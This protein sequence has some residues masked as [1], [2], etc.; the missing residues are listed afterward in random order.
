MTDHPPIDPA[1]IRKGDHV[2]W[3]TDGDPMVRYEAIEYVALR[4]GDQAAYQ[5][6]TWTLIARAPRP[7]V[8]VD[9]DALDDLRAAH[10][11]LGHDQPAE[12]KGWC[13]TCCFLAAV[14]A[15][16]EDNDR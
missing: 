4:D 15:A 1:D 2:R 11:N 8:P 12:A 13:A 7:P 3:D 9:A 14:D 16:R 5:T 10:V 6:G